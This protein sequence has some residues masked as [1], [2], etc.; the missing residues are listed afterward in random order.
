MDG[1]AAAGT[2]RGTMVVPDGREIAYRHIESGDTSALQRFH[3]RLSERSVYQRFFGVMPELSDRQAAYFT[4][5]GCKL[6]VP[7]TPGEWRAGD[8]FTS[9][10]T[11]GRPHT[12]T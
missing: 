1:I 6:P 2:L 8:I 9:L 5:A 7:V 4:R 12:G 11:G 10:V 3:A